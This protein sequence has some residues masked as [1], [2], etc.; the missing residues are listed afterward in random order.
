[1][2]AKAACLPMEIERVDW[3]LREQAHS[4][5]SG[6]QLTLSAIPQDLWDRGSAHPLSHPAKPVG[7]SL[8]AKA[9]CL[10]MEIQCVDWPIR[11]QARSHGIGGRLS[12]QPFR[13]TCG[14]RGQLILSAISQNLWE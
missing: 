5:M 12:S 4:H 2:L 10:P 7:V 13:K 8:L 6:V 1:L 9:A 3:P 11:E 14:I